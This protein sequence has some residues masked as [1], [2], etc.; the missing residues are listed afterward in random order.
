MARAASWRIRRRQPTPTSDRCA[1]NLTV[2]LALARELDRDHHRVVS[3]PG[4]SAGRS[5]DDLPLYVTVPTAP[6]RGAPRRSPASAARSGSRSHAAV[7]AIAVVAGDEPSLSPCFSRLIDVPGGDLPVVL[8]QW[9]AWGEEDGRVAVG[10]HLLLVAPRLE[11]GAWAT[12]GWLRGARRRTIPVEIDLWSH[13]RFFT[14]LSMSPQARVV[15]SR[16]YF[17]VGNAAVALF[18]GQLCDC[19]GSRWRG[20]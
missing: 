8:H 15:T 19:C 3:E 18:A 6:H 13:N 12:R 1:E 16:R 17:A 14:R 11:H 4:V 10:E 2:S 20:A 9:W 5:L 7:A